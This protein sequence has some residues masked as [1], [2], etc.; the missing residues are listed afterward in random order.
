MY[1]AGQRGTARAGAHRV[2]KQITGFG[3]CALRLSKCFLRQRPRALPGGFALG[4]AATGTAPCALPCACLGVAPRGIPG[5]G[6]APA[7]RHPFGTRQKDAKAR[8]RAFPPLACPLGRSR[9]PALFLPVLTSALGR[10]LPVA[11]CKFQG[12][13]SLQSG[14]CPAFGGIPSG[15]ARI[16]SAVPRLP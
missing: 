13:H 3:Q 4:C 10:C 14:T 11:S 9:R 15:N 2:T 12:A 8:Q 7:R 5:R 6:C 16:H 1:P